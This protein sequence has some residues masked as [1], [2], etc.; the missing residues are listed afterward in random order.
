MYTID[1]DDDVFEVL[2][3]EARPLLDSPNDVLRR[4]LLSDS[5]DE[6]ESKPPKRPLKTA[7]PTGSPAEPRPV[8]RRVAGRLFPLVK[9]GLIDDG[10]ELRHTRKRTGETYLAQV[11]YLGRV[12]LPNNKVFTEP[13]PA[14]RHYVGSEI[15]GWANWTHV[16]SGKTLRLLRSELPS[17]G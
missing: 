2:Q 3:R 4:L 12:V 13:S 1:V 10:D 16:R 14:L 17:R 11:D 9:A 15:D 7:Q 6:G 8:L 5:D